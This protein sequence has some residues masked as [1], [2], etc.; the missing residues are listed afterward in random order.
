M[1]VVGD[2]MEMTQGS[3]PDKSSFDLHDIVVGAGEMA[4]FLFGENNAKTRMRIYRLIAM[5]S[6]DRLPHFKMGSSIAT[7]RA[8]LIGNCS[9]GWQTGRP[10]MQ[11][12]VGPVRQKPYIQGADPS[13]SQPREQLPTFVC[14]GS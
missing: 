12:I 2:V 11:D 7:K 1:T 14:V 5:R 6:K 4:L 3:Q 10:P 9:R 8:C 13:L